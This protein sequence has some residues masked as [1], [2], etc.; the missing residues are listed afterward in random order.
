MKKDFFKR[1]RMKS[2]EK[3][4]LAKIRIRSPVGFSTLILSI[5]YAYKTP[6]GLLISS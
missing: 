3:Q 5:E 6:L 4:E 2:A 1:K